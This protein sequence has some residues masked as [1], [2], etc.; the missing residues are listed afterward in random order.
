MTII[1]VNTL[2]AGA[3]QFSKIRSPWIERSIWLSVILLLCATNVMTLLHR[4]FRGS[5]YDVVARMAARSVLEPIGLARIAQIVE[6]AN[7]V[8]LERITVAQATA[9]TMASSVLMQQ[10]IAGLKRQRLALAVD[11][12]NLQNQLR[13]SQAAIALHKDRASELGRKV[14]RRAA[15]SVTRNLAALPGHA[16]PVLSA[17]VAV[18]SVA[19]DI[20]DACESVKELDALNRGIGLPLAD[21]SGI[22]GESVPTAEEILDLA[23][24]N[25]RKAYE[26]S[27]SALNDRVPIIPWTP[28]AVSLESARKWL[29]ATVAR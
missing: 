24:S 7:P 18:G 14:L 13:N 20:Q 17:T 1:P 12:K 27:A 22:C 10:E 3:G 11:R 28:P 29:S 2:G 15:R 23:R 4:D 16:L 5:A 19:L 21:S 9:R 8:A 25:W 6:N 26:R